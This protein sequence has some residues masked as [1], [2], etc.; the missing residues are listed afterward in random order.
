MKNISKITSKNVFVIAMFSLALL[1]PGV[2]LQQAYA[3]SEDED[4]N[5]TKIDKLEQKLQTAKEKITK[6]QT[7]KDNLEEKLEKAKTKGNYVRVQNLEEKI[8]KKET[9]LAKLEAK[10]A[11]IQEKLSDK[12]SQ[13]SATK[14]LIDKVEKRIDKLNA[15]IAKAE[16]NGNSDKV[17]RLNEKLV[18]AENRL[19]KL[20]DRVDRQYA[21]DNED[22]VVSGYE[23][24]DIS[25]AFSA[26]E[27][28][29]S[30][31][32]NIHLTIDM[33][34]ISDA[35]AKDVEIMNE[36]AELSNKAVDAL[37]TIGNGAL[38][39][40][41][42]E[43]ET[44]KFHTMLNPDNY[45]HTHTTPV[46]TKTTGSQITY[47]MAEIIDAPINT[48]F[49]VLITPTSHK[50]PYSG[51]YECGVWAW[52]VPAE[53]PQGQEGTFSS[54]NVARE[55]LEDDGFTLVLGYASVSELR[56]NDYSKVSSGKGGCNGG[57]FRDQSVVYGSAG[58]GFSGPHILTDYNEPNPEIFS[59]T[60]PTA[61]WPITV[62]VY[63]DRY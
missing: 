17:D 11:K 24:E 1:K 57:E 60:P 37:T 56:G 12:Q 41:V 59:Y 14:Y 5:R 32:E 13:I 63:H 22:A 46:S 61:W 3:E 55:K 20:N 33:E 21:Q 16:S 7:T 8:D 44:G 28:H 10:Y 34:N 9:K 54:A 2:A 4:K 26:F 18:K 62:A 53:G 52:Q 43:Y 6:V 47:V 36:Y 50:I 15:K 35:T 39:S 30:Y 48:A 45:E 40:V 27:G 58:H 42:E 51:L 49:G 25:E 23:L 29:T 31:D 19:A 38:E